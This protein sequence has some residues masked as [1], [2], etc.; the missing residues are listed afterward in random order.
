[1][2]MAA[3]MPLGNLVFT[4]F[5]CAM[6]PLAISITFMAFYWSLYADAI[7]VND[8]FPDQ[9]NAFDICGIRITSIDGESHEGNT[10]WT[11]VFMLNAVIYTI[12][13]LITLCLVCSSVYTPCIMCGAAGF[14]CAQLVHLGSLVVTG[15]V[16]Y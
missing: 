4:I 14:F 7:K 10:M 13:T 15:L 11:P 5:L 6:C 2:D 1:M 8:A 9:P 3:K 16:R 12:L